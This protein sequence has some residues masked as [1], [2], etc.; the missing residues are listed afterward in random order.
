MSFKHKL[1]YILEDINN[2]KLDRDSVYSIRVQERLNKCL[3]AYIY[4]TN[5]SVEYLKARDSL[6]VLRNLNRDS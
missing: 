5:V 3:E 1:Y 6:N 2:H 4:N